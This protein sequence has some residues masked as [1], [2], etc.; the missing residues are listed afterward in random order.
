ME[1]IN[2]AKTHK[3]RLFDPIFE[4]IYTRQHDGTFLSEFGVKVKISP[5]KSTSPNAPTKVLVLLNP[6]GGRVSGIF[7][8]KF[9]S[10]QWVF[11]VDTRVGRINYVIDPLDRHTFKVTKTEGGDK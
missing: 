6:P 11:N 5:T 9:R 4:G 2:K 10:T 1:K 8:S 3:V 7:Q